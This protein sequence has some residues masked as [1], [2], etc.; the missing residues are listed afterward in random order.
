MMGTNN[1]R[2]EK[3][4][5]TKDDDRKPF[6][7]NL[8]SDID[9]AAYNRPA[10]RYSGSSESELESTQPEA[11]SRLR[12]TNLKGNKGNNRSK[13]SQFNLVAN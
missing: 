9:L 12:S 5:F 4:K 2:S 11:F 7:F 13:M 1:L 8:K 6:L 3:Y 10:F